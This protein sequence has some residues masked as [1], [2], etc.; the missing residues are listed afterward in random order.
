MTNIPTAAVCLLFQLNISL[1]ADGRPVLLSIPPRFIGYYI[2]IIG[3][4]SLSRI[5]KCSRNIIPFSILALLETVKWFRGLLNYDYWNTKNWEAISILSTLAVLYTTK[6]LV[7]T[8][9]RA[10]TRENVKAG[11]DKISK[12]WRVLAS[13]SM[14]Q[15]LANKL[16][17][18][19]TSILWV[20]S[21]LLAVVMCV[22]IR[23]FKKCFFDKLPNDRIEY[24]R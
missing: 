10:E 23:G 18:Q 6:V 15:L 7:N 16:L 14:L 22:Y 20:V 4:S 2:L 5:D 17:P 8:I 24:Y 9:A 12:I 19:V 13:V 11:A 1:I 3:C 21:L